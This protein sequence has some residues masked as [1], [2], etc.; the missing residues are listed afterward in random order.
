MMPSIIHVRISVDVWVLYA[1]SS[2]QTG[3]AASKM[4]AS[5][6]H[7]RILVDIW[8]QSAGSSV[9]TAGPGASSPGR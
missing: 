9:Q 6:I 7:V 4:V 8:V 2:V 1:G 5:I 3:G